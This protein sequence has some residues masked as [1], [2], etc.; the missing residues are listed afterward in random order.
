VVG[1]NILNESLA[2]QGWSPKTQLFASCYFGWSTGV[3]ANASGPGIV[4]NPS[5]AVDALVIMDAAQANAAL[6]VDTAGTIGIRS[7]NVT[8]SGLGAS[9]NPVCTTTG[10]KL[11][12]A[13]C[14]VGITSISS[15]DGSI[16]INNP[17][18]TPTLQLSTD[19]SYV[20]DN[21]PTSAAPTTTRSAAVFQATGVTR[22]TI[23]QV[24]FAYNTHPSLTVTAGDAI[25]SF[26]QGASNL[27]NDSLGDTFHSIFSSAS[28]ASYAYNIV[29]GTG[30][31]G[32]AGGVGVIV[33]ELANVP[34]TAFLDAFTVSAVTSSPQAISVAT[35]QSNDLLLSGIIQGSGFNTAGVATGGTW[36]N[37]QSGAQNEIMVAQNTTLA[38]LAGTYSTTWIYP[39]GWNDLFII[40]FKGMTATQTADIVPYKNAA[41]TV[42]SKINFAAY[43]QDVAVTFATLPSCVAGLEGT[44]AAVTD[45]TTNSYGATITGAGSNHVPAYCN[46]TNWIVY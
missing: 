33:Y 36:A 38:G 14:L 29:G 31:F 20:W 7:P 35:T 16:N 39:S 30:T 15:P 27:G 37:L 28:T 19:K 41:G 5:T 32:C 12:N 1:A 46:G 23:V 8:D 11:T 40:A 6:H 24:V 26:C 44:K 21:T 34:T 45:S 17:S 2:L 22:P 13:G 42:I 25:V 9:T 3:L 4:C 43:A 18:V 10:G